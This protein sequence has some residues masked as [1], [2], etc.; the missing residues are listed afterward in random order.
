MLQRIACGHCNKDP[1]L[2]GPAKTETAFNDL[3][4]P[5]DVC[6]E[7]GG[8]RI[9]QSRRR[10]PDC[11]DPLARPLWRRQTAMGASSLMGAPRYTAALPPPNQW[12]TVVVGKREGF[13]DVTAA[14]TM[15]MSRVERQAAVSVNLM[16]EILTV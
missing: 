10:L 8:G 13:S 3:H 11:T 4:R 6:C 9:D 15:P 2:G 1:W 7:R 12:V 14:R 5:G 16:T